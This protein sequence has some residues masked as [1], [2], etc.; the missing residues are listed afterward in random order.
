MSKILIAVD[1]SDLAVE[2]AATAVD[3]LG[4]AHSYTVLEAFHVVIPGPVSRL[5]DFPPYAIPPAP[6]DLLAESRGSSVSHELL[7]EPPCPVLV[8]PVRPAD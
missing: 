3:L 1:G 8:V 7:K 4:P 5:G 6:E 2:A